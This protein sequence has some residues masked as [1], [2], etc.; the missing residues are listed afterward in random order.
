[1][2][3]RTKVELPG[4]ETEIRHSDRILLFGSCFAENVS[5]L[6]VG[7]KFR[8]D[9]NPFGILYNPCSVGLAL[10]QIADGKVYTS[11]DLF[12]ADGLWHSWMHHGDFSAPEADACLEKVNTRLKAA[13]AVLDMQDWLI[14]TWGTAY[15]YFHRELRQVVGN[16]HK[17]SERLF[18]R[19]RLSVGEIVDEWLPL[20]HEL[21]ARNPKLK[22]MLTVSPIR[23]L[24]DGLHANQLSKGTLLLAADELCRQMSDVHYF[25][26][27]EILTDELRDYRFYAED[28]TH[29]SEVAVKYVW[30]CFSE[31]CFSAETK[32][33]LKEWEAV[34]K[35]LAHR[36][37]R[38]DTEAYR[39]FI[40]QIVLKITQIKEKLPYIEVQKELELCEPRLNTLLKN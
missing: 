20:L 15:V 5:K 8:C 30:E 9:V 14:V 24:R 16:C 18:E 36:P 1:M 4:K 7:N 23:H 32:R 3:F 34:R 22:V 19:H 31:T 39:T 10:R 21:K 17:Q 33:I 26:A 2:D 38:P 12:E 40:S 13:A 11:D 29:P 28:M 37:S 27:Y 35:G 6:L 25:P